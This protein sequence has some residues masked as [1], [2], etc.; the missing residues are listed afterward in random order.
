M[1]KKTLLKIFSLAATFMAVQPLQA[2]MYTNA[3]SDY[4]CCDP[5][6]VCQNQ[7]WLEADYLYWQIQDSPK[8]IPLVIEQPEINGAFDVVLGGK[9]I[10][11]D[12]HSGARF[13]I[14]YWF[15][16]CKSLGV[17][18][19]Y[20]FLGKK[21]KHSSVTS[22]ENGSPRLRV[23]YF[24]VI[25][26]EPASIA[27]AT[28]GVFRGSAALKVSNKMQGAELNVVKA[29]PCSAFTLL[30]GFRYWNFEDNLTF[31]AN[32]PF[33]PTPTIYN[34]QDKFNTENNFYG[35]QI[36]ASYRQTFS[37]FF[38]DVRGK[39]ALGA[40]CQ[41]SNINGEFHTNEFTGSEETFEGG[42]FALP[43]NIGHHKKT[44][45]AVIPEVNLNLGYNITDNFCI[46]VG[47]S[48]LYASRV[49]RSA[50]QMSS[51]LNPTQSANIEF[52]PTPELVGEASPKSKLRSTGL[53]AQ[54]L[55][56]G[57]DLTF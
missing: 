16:E 25:T 18:A 45:F 1:L 12:W 23:P 56:V 36:G 30:A 14:G 8:V 31:S 32:S 24:N 35:G 4:S 3:G 47:Y 2:Q 21:S 41:K 42:F 44:T 53:W 27:L 13:A 19:S 55:N 33:I 22:D 15:D 28:P 9:K 11:N 57:L 39:L 38:F 17:E 26:E 5:C 48:A 10:K 52:T 50:K 40:M 43:T 49:L 20:F 51:S 37:C 54:G 29:M 6:N 7:F 46:Y 34:F